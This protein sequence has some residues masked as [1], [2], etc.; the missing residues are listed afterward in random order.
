MARK[1]KLLPIPDY[2]GQKAALTISEFRS[3]PGRALDFVSLG[4]EITITKNGKLIA[5]LTQ[6]DT[7]IFPD[8]TWTGKRPI[9]MGGKL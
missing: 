8:G 1:H 9:T 5:C 3:A 2:T 7:T 4:G 6:P